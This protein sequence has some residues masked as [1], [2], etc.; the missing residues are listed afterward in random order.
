MRWPRSRVSTAHAG[1]IVKRT[2]RSRDRRAFMTISPEDHQPWCTPT[3]RPHTQ[4]NE[5]VGGAPYRRPPSASHGQ[6]PLS[7]AQ[8]DQ[9]AARTASAVVQAT[10]FT[11]RGGARRGR[12][13][14]ALSE[15]WRVRRAQVRQE[16]DSRGHPTERQAVTRH[17][18]R[19][20]ARHAGPGIRHA[21]RPARGG[22]G[23]EGL[24]PLPQSPQPRQLCWHQT[25]P[26]HFRHPTPVLPDLLG[27]TP[28]PHP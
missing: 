2:R 16:V 6:R 4:L 24:K 25:E 11:R 26:A 8:Q 9:D 19:L 23:P 18:D 22:H 27:T 3:R 17:G 28:N 14:T 21:P 15:A 5:G 1:K 12:R 20:S 10:A 7:P 13:V